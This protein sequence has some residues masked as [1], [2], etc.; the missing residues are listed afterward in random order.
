MGPT[1]DDRAKFKTFYAESRRLSTLTPTETTSNADSM[2]TSTHITTAPQAPTTLREEL[3]YMGRQQ[4]TPTHFVTMPA[5]TV[6]LDHDCAH[7]EPEL[8]LS[9]RRNEYNAR[10][11]G[12]STRSQGRARD[13]HGADTDA[14]AVTLNESTGTTGVNA[15]PNT[16]TPT[17]TLMTATTAIIEAPNILEAAASI[18]EKA[19][20][21]AT[22]TTTA[23]ACTANTAS[24]RSNASLPWAH[25]PGCSPPWS[26]LPLDAIKRV[27]D[28]ILKRGARVDHGNQRDRKTRKTRKRDR[29]N[30]V[31]HAASTCK[32]WRAKFGCYH[33][34]DLNIDLDRTSAFPP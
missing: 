31:M 21:P 34:S 16:P 14:E 29:L 2:P 32:Q 5:V 3:E 18:L 24:P 23:A 33:A 1:E 22:A 17:N 12:S 4:L 9:K 15:T 27:V 19:L 10:L 26:E 13:A 20:L 6:P 25:A 30:D 11:Q 28:Y 8:Q 7:D